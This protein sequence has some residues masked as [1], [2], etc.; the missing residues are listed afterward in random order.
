[1]ERVAVVAYRFF[2]TSHFLSLLRIFGIVEILFGWE[3]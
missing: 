3:W 1:V 2:S